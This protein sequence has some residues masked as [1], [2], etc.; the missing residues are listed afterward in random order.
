[1]PN[2]SLVPTS[3]QSAAPMLVDAREAARLLAISPRSLWSQSWPRGP[4]PV[5]CL[6]GMR[7]VRYSVAA[8]QQFIIEQQ[9][10]A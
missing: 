4:I 3:L 5:V 1:M 9:S 8:L 2:T 10:Q 6:P 7:A